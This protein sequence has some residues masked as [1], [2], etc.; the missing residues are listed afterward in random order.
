MPKFVFLIEKL[1]TRAEDGYFI[2]NLRLPFSNR[3]FSLI[4]WLNL[5]SHLA[6]FNYNGLRIPSL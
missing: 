1:W 3:F 6:A 4:G 5:S 2:V